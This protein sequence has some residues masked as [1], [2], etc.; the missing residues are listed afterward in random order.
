MY[1]VRANFY[2]GCYEE[3]VDEPL[4]GGDVDVGRDSV[5]DIALGIVSRQ[6]QVTRPE[7]LRQHQ[8]AELGWLYCI[9]LELY[10]QRG[11]YRHE[12]EAECI[13]KRLTK[14]L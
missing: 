12:R 1:V 2:D 7:G 9:R 8:P 11:L 6:L 5:G 10:V 14:C 4:T 3:R 13:Q